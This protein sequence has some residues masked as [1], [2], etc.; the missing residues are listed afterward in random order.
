ME[1]ENFNGFNSSEKQK[2]EYSKLEQLEGYSKKLWNKAKKI[3]E[4]VGAKLTS[5]DSAIEEMENVEEGSEDSLFLDLDVVRDGKEMKLRTIAQIDPEYDPGREKNYEEWD[6]TV[7]EEAERWLNREILIHDKFSKFFKDLDIIADKKKTGNRLSENGEMYI[8]KDTLEESTMLEKMEEFGEDEG[9]VLV[10]S[11]LVLHSKMKN[12]DS[13]DES[14]KYCADEMIK[15]IMKEEGIKDK[16][17]L[18]QKIFEDYFDHFKGYKENSEND[19]L[20]WFDDK[21]FANRIKKKME[22]YKDIMESQQLPD[23]QYA[24]VHGNLNFDTISYSESDSNKKAYFSDWHRPGTTLNRE[25]ALVY[26]LGNVYCDIIEKI[27]DAGQRDSFMKGIEDE[28]R[29]YYKENP[30]VAEAVINLTKLR[31][32]SMLMENEDVRDIVKGKLEEL[33]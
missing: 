1:R 16:T 21:D 10:Q 28:I 9:K 12:E 6:L 7:Q 22:T 19:A 4:R 24:L 27:D 20:N 23:G 30:E 29:E 5:E 17:E 8:L 26:D 13:K 2:K 14:I 15:E 11:L 32:F 3:L 33:L 18:E 31:S 25:L